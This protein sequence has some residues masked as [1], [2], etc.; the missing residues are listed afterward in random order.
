MK[1]LIVEDNAEMRRL[2]A[3]LVR[4]LAEAVSECG[5]GAEALANYREHRPDWVL[6]DIRMKKMDGIAATKQIM[7]AFPGAH[8]L[9]VTDYDDA[10]LREAAHR[11]G[12][13]GYVVKENLLSLR[14]LLMPEVRPITAWQA[15]AV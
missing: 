2:I 8:V 6:M 10:K 9:I 12:A 15:D 3:S 11:A 14:Q 1:L 4:D 7:A 13:C 5:D